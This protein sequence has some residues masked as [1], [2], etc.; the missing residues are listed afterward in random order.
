MVKK[1]QGARAPKT[2]SYR[3]RNIL[4]FPAVGAGQGIGHFKRCLALVKKAQGRAGLILPK[5]ESLPKE[6]YSLL[7]G[8]RIKKQLPPPSRLK[9]VVMDR[10]QTPLSLIRTLGERVPFIGLDEGGKWR[11]Y[12]PYLIDT[13]P[14]IE[15]NSTPNAEFPA[16]LGA[17]HNRQKPL[18]FPFKR[19]VL[20][21]GGEDVR[22]LTGK[23][24][25]LLLKEKIFKPD[26][27]SLIQGPLFKN[28]SW[29]AG[30]RVYRNIHDISGILKKHDLVFTHF[31]LTCYESLG[32]SV[33]VIVFNPSPYHSRLSKRAGFPEI[34]VGKAK[35]GLLRKILADKEL[36]RRLVN[37]RAERVRAAHQSLIQFLLQLKFSG[38]TSCPFC[39]KKLNKALGR[40][41]ER[42]YF[43]CSGCGMIYMLSCASKQHSY[44]KNYF[45]SEYKKQYGRTY[46]NDFSFIHAL[47]QTRLNKI[48]PLLPDN[49]RNRLLDI[50]CAYGPFLKAASNL[51]FRV[52]GIDISAEAVHY[53]KERLHLPCQKRDFEQ[54]SPSFLARNK[55]G[56]DV[57]SMWFVVEHFQKLN[58][59]FASVNRLLKRGGVFAF[60]TPSVKGISAR[61][62]L[63]SFLQQ[64]PSDH[65]TIWNPFLVKK[66]LKRFGF[67]V[68]RIR[69][70]GHHAERFFQKGGMLSPVFTIIAPLLLLVSKLLHLGDTFE[71]YATKERE[72]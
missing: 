28:S 10:R 34:G 11:D 14:V 63:T 18:S 32:L 29:P 27:I 66:Q 41:K 67:R 70:T 35:I 19:V 3:N 52:Q 20:S 42:S 37:R 71:V 36:F 31:G 23:L 22:N 46:L 38:S 7:S 45:F 12:F 8:M 65:F 56:Y 13:L 5:Q 55:K 6:F 40:F 25:D 72:I 1:T 39:L 57:I 62:D 58:K 69:I 51:G 24:L 26:D 9:L 43:R 64:S 47:A 15:G 33:P 21:F 68:K 60:S 59:I 16:M 61:K 30:I 2:K 44:D 17:D 49:S 50:G 54:L 48:L 53:V 4:F